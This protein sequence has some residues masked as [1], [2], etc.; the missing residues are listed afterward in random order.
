MNID[1]TYNFASTDKST[2]DATFVQ[3]RC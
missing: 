1:R 2:N 3:I